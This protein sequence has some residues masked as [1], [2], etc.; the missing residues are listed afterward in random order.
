[1]NDVDVSNET[2]LKTIV[3][4]VAT[5]DASYTDRHDDV[6][7][8]SKHLNGLDRIQCKRPYLK[9]ECDGSMIEARIV[10]VPMCL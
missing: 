4:R 8:V 10:L 6:N 2:S 1:V 3:H 7:Y 9:L 5:S